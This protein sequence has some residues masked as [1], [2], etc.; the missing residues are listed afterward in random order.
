[1]PYTIEVKHDTAHRKWKV[2]SVV[3]IVPERLIEDAPAHAQQY[4]SDH[5]MNPDQLACRVVEIDSS[6]I[7]QNPLSSY[8]RIVF[9]R[10]SAATANRGAAV[11]IMARSEQPTLGSEFAAA[12]QNHCPGTNTARMGRSSSMGFNYRSPKNGE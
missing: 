2:L 10:V 12:N 11:P 6:Q 5:Q 7:G 4:A 1:M 8:R 9:N 3:A